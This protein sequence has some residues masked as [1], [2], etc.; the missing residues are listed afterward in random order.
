MLLPPLLLAAAPLDRLR[1]GGL[2]LSHVER[3]RGLL[4]VAVILGL[5]WLLSY[6]RRRIRWRLVGA[7]LA[8][9]AAFGLLVLKT[10]FGRWLFET[11]GR[12]ASG[13]LG[14]SAE[15]ARFVFGNLVQPLVP[16][17]RSQ[18]GGSIDTTAGFV[19]STAASFAFGVLPTIIFFSAL[20]SVL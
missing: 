16:V 20:M 5:A 19:A 10:T 4:G 18:A 9:Q 14:F 13:L 15:G 11:V 1:E 7:G 6:D 12:I 2:Q 3:A 17:G 8:L